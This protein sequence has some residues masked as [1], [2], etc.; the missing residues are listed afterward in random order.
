MV[1]I[2]KSVIIYKNCD[3]LPVYNFMKVINTDDLNWL[4][5]N[6]EEDENKY[7]GNLEIFWDRIIKEYLDL[8][9]DKKVL[10]SYQARIIIKRLE[11][12]LSVC[13]QLID[14]CTIDIGLENIEK[15]SNSLQ[16][17]DK[18]YKINLKKPLEI[19][20]KRILKSFIKLQFSIDIKKS[21]FDK[22]FG[23][24]EKDNG[25]LDIWTEMGN[26]E[27]ALKRNEI[28]PKTTV[29]AKWIA[30]CNLSKKQNG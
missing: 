19:E 30:L 22:D 15:I 1:K 17:H 14:V 4:V 25:K 26:L 11:D 20:K 12:K 6:Y 8:K 9:K 10:Q 27:Q 16:K 28:N 24:T 29:V 5:K 13:T 7:E 18:S 2:N 3:M 21:N 23:S